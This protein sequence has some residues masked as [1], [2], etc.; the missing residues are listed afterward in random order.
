MLR[1]GQRSLHALNSA[2]K[3]HHSLCVRPRRL[4]S[5]M[6][7]ESWLRKAK[8]GWG[9]GGLSRWAATSLSLRFMESSGSSQWEDKRLLWA[10]LKEGCEKPQKPG[11]WHLQYKNDTEGKLTESGFS[12]QGWGWKERL[13]KEDW[14]GGEGS[15]R[16]KGRWEVELR[17]QM[18]GQ[19]YLWVESMRDTR[20]VFSCCS[21]QRGRWGKY[22]FFWS[23]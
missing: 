18:L 9:G 17:D 3:K 12:L 16:E 10:W 11:R 13:V 8:Q 6:G 15:G 14:E 5:V 19:V 2:R 20:G 23:L 22:L 7:N 21:V 4:I 1:R